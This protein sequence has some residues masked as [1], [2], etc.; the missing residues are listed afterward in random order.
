MRGGSGGGGS[1]RTSIKA[2]L[3]VLSSQIGTGWTNAIIHDS[4]NPH[5]TVPL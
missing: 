4:A 3:I 2:G 5:I 1:R